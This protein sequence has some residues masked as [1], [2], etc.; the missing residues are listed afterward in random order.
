MLAAGATVNAC[1]LPSR[2]GLPLS[3]FRAKDWKLISG[4]PEMLYSRDPIST[5]VV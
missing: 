1:R 4:F 3:T 2:A 5:F